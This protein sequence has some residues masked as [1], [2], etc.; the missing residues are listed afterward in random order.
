MF[1]YVFMQMAHADWDTILIPSQCAHL[2]AASIVRSPV[3]V[4]LPNSKRILSH[5]LM[6]GERDWLAM[7]V[8]CPAS[9]ALTVGLSGSIWYAE[10]SVVKTPEQSL[11]I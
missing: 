7:A 10:D 4:N 1:S 5:Q 9:W 3:T 2:K 8:S 11:V 6:A